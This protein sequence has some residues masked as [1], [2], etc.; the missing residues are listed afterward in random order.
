MKLAKLLAAA[1][2]ACISYSKTLVSCTETASSETR[3]CDVLPL[4]KNA[5]SF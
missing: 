1:W 4:N 2:K 3:R 5:S